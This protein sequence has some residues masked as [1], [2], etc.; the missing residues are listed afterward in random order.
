MTARAVTGRFVLD[1]NPELKCPSGPS[2]LACSSVYGA[3]HGNE[4][5]DA[6][7]GL[8]GALAAEPPT[9]GLKP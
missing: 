6:G 5:L 2:D 3:P 9:Q 4:A 7:P 1:D 8:F